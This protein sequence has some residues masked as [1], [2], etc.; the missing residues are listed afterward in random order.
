LLL[1]KN[2]F[3]YFAM[4]NELHVNEKEGGKSLRYRREKCFDLCQ[5][6]YTAIAEIN[7]FRFL[8]RS[9]VYWE[10][11]IKRNRVCGGPAPIHSA[12]LE[13][14]DHLGEGLTQPE[15]RHKAG[16]QGKKH[17]ILP[18]RPFYGNPLHRQMPGLICLCL[19]FARAS[20]AWARIF[21]I[22]LI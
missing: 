10:I 17:W 7:S 12:L 13:G 11:A 21:W 2:A 20:R 9:R 6:L 4:Q 3:A 19:S 18:Q 14:T 22:W 5:I 15:A 1:F 16:L 8:Q